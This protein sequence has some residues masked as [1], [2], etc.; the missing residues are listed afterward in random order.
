MYS[1]EN[2]IHQQKK[3]SIY[4]D[5]YSCLWA[6]QLSREHH[7]IQSLHQ[8]TLYSPNCPCTFR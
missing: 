5:A 8:P 2:G 4:T 7:H 6:Q 3:V 1:S